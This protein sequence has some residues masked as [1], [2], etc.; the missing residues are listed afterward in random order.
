MASLE[1]ADRSA[2]YEAPQ[3]AGVRSEKIGLNDLRNND[4]R[5]KDSPDKDSRNHDSRKIDLPPELDRKIARF[6]AYWKK[7]SSGSWPVYPR[8]S[9]D[10]E[11]ASL[12][13]RIGDEL[14][15][16]ALRAL[17]HFTAFVYCYAPIALL[18]RYRGAK[19]QPRKPESPALSQL[20]P[21]LI[22][23]QKSGS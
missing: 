11:P 14:Y 1:G 16:R 23:S 8:S 10:S 3:H 12:P 15:F 21:K 9:G 13:E 20:E 18:R 19:T 4:S 17:D 5:D 6:V 22:R 7:E 2:I